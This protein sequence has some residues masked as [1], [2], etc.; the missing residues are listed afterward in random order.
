MA[1]CWSHAHT[2]AIRPYRASQTGTR[3]R[4]RDGDA[5][6]NLAPSRPVARRF[7]RDAL[8]AVRS[9]SY[10]DLEPSL[11]RTVFL[12][13]SGRSGTTWVQELIDRHHDHRVMF[14]PFT[15]RR[16]PQV[17]HFHELQ[18]LRCDDPAP[19]YFEPVDAILRG[20]V[21]N[22]WI[23]HRNHVRIARKRLVK[24]IRS[25]LLLCWLKHRRPTL[26]IIWLIRHPVAVVTS[27]LRM[28]WDDHLDDLLAQ[29]QLL[30]DHMQDHHDFLRDL[31]DDVGRRAA[32]WAIEHIVPL[33]QL[34]PDDVHLVFYEDL[35]RR[36][37]RVASNMLAF[38][39]Q[40]WDDAARRV[41]ARPS[42]MARAGGAIGSTDPATSW[43]SRVDGQTQDR[44]MAVVGQLGLGG[45]YGSDGMPHHGCLQQF[46][47][48]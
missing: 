7:L 48:R 23:D 25:N 5:L 47:N 32:Q 34:V 37:A 39:G 45:L 2:T 38:L 10:V 35:V 13:G 11:A 21:R 46:R 36:P 31:R 41:I 27:S 33:R 24:D 12:A 8:W 29:P 14:E 42:H 19:A 15:P 3:R 4:H 22:R 6:M 26:Q 17:A 9:M 1:S 30:A 44:V 20:R 18:Y 16:V 40:T 43:Q 28:G